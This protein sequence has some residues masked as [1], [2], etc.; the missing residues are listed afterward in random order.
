MSIISGTWFSYVLLDCRLAPQAKAS[1]G[2]GLPTAPR[3]HQSCSY[4]LAFSTAPAGAD[5]PV[6]QRRHQRLRR[7]ARGM[8]ILSGDQQ[9]VADD[10]NAPV[11]LFRKDGAQFQ[12]LI[13]DQEGHD[14]GEADRL[15]LAVGEAGNFLVLDQELA[16][17]RLDMTQRARGMTYHSD[18]LA[19]G[20][21]G[22]DQLD[23]SSCLRRD[24]TSGR[25]RPGRRRCRSLPA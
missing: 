25:G 9:A 2:S 4:A 10:V 14:L 15:F 17:R 19:G 11:H 24:P 7:R 5:L 21:E 18:C 22:L 20:K 3:Q 6:R 23:R 1:T 16:V 8:R 13:F 12:H